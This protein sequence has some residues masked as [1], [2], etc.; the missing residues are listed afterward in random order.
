M[1]PRADLDII[2]TPTEVAEYGLTDRGS[3]TVVTISHV[4]EV[5]AFVLQDRHPLEGSFRVVGDRAQ[6]SYVRSHRLGDELLRLPLAAGE[7]D[8]ILFSALRLEAL[9]RQPIAGRE[10]VSDPTSLCRYL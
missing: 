9:L 5:I 6:G 1:Q 4:I 7:D 3:I 10:R 8:L 2:T